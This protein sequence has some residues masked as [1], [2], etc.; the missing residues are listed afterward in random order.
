MGT[1]LVQLY[2]TASDT[3]KY[4]P[5]DRNSSWERPFEATSDSTDTI[6]D[7]ASSRVQGKSLFY[8]AWRST[9]SWLAE[10][11]FLYRAEAAWQNPKFNIYNFWQLHIPTTT[12]FIT[13]S[14]M[15]LRHK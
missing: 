12:T 4:I 7:Q 14:S 11:N 1:D 8:V 10:E 6:V 9:A 15:K 2:L 5:L 13:A 3:S